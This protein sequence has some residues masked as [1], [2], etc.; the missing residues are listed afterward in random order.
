MFLEHRAGLYGG[1]CKAAG[2]REQGRD[3]QAVPSWARGRGAREG[4]GREAWG[5]CHAF[6]FSHHCFR[7]I[8]SDR[9]LPSECRPGIL[10]T[11]ESR[12]AQLVNRP[13]WALCTARSGYLPL[14]PG[15]GER[16]IWAPSQHEN[17][18]RVTLGK[19]LALSPKG[20]EL[21][22]APE[23]DDTGPQSKE[24]APGTEVTRHGAAACV[25][26]VTCP[27]LVFPGD[28]TKLPCEMILV[29]ECTLLHVVNFH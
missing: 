3:S 25:E 24:N 26:G 2:P 8:C 5:Q 23:H 28:K 17:P 13:D 7:G 4:P 20:P 9:R 15:T 16:S 22:R 11:G 12:R 27:V 21:A 18:C 1:F 14:V 19:G 10:G 29:I 6:P